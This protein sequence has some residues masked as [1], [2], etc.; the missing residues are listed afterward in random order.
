LTR[1]GLHST[2]A[3]HVLPPLV[4]I[5]LGLGLSLPAAMSQSTLGVRLSDQG[6]ASAT[7]NTTQQIGG[8]IST[9][10]LNSLANAAAA[11]YVAAHLTDPLVQA[12]A[13]MRSYE[14]AFWWS[15]GFFAVGAVIAALLFRR[16]GVGGSV[17]PAPATVAAR[18][19]AAS[20]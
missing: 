6:V 4:V 11:T 12:N 5:G 7:M 19:L 9:A 8:A 13:A 20:T 17:V 16:K 14:T 2:Y 3:A 1:L 15:A 18:L 10:L